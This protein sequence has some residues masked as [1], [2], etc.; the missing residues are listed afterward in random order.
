MIPLILQGKNNQEIADEIGASRQAVSYW[1]NHDDDFKDNLRTE[2]KAYRDTQRAKFAQ[3]LD[4]AYQSL[5][6]LLDS[7]DPA[8][9]L[10]AAVE[11]LKSSNK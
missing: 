5:E 4:K 3:V 7:S 11:I 9:K 6:A 1:R 8:I 10:K 2:I